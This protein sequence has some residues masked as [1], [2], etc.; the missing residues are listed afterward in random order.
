MAKGR[1]EKKGAAFVPRSFL[2]SILMVWRTDATAAVPEVLARQLIDSIAFSTVLHTDAEQAARL[3]EQFPDDMPGVTRAD[4][5]RALDKYLD[6][7]HLDRQLIHEVAAHLDSSAVDRSLRW[8]SSDSGRT[9]SKAESGAYA[10]M[11][12][13]SDF[14]LYHY[15]QRPSAIPAEDETSKA[16]DASGF[17]RFMTDMFLATGEQRA[18]VVTTVQS[19]GLCARWESSTEELKSDLRRF[20][21]AKLRGYYARAE[22]ADLG[23]Y[24]TYL[25]LHSSDSPEA[26]LRA[27][28][29]PIV[30]QAWKGALLSVQRARGR[31]P[32]PETQAAAQGYRLRPVVDYVDTQ[33]GAG[34]TGSPS[35][36]ILTHRARDI[37]DE[38]P[39]LNVMVGDPTVPKID[40]SILK[41]ATQLIGRSLALD[42]DNPETLMEAGYI[43]YLNFDLGKSTQL[44]ERARTL[45][46]TDPWLGVRLADL[47]WAQ[48]NQTFEKALAQRAADEFEKALRLALPTPAEDRAVYQLGPIYAFLNDVPRADA[49]YRR[50]LDYRPEGLP[51]AYALHR[52]AIFLLYNAKDVDASLKIMRQSEATADFPIGRAF[53]ASVLAVKAGSLKET[54]QWSKGRPYIA[55]AR[56]YIPDLPALLPDLARLPAGL[57]AV[58]GIAAAE[59]SGRL[60]ASIA[61]RVLVHSML[62]ANASQ[63]P[64]LLAFG[65]DVNYFDAED[66]TALH[67]AILADNVEAT[68]TL[69]ALGADPSAPFLDGRTP[70]QLA[71]DSGDPKR[72]EI[73][74]LIK[75]ALGDRGVSVVGT[76]LKAGYE[77]EIVRAIDGDRWGNS[78]AVGDHVVFVNNQCGYTDTSLACLNVEKIQD[79]SRQLDIAI[80]KVELVN[81][82]DIF[83]ELGPYKN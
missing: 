11:F 2:V 12:S 81:W 28:E 60:P 4:I 53:L 47:Y 34:T 55:E 19:N 18:C 6:Y 43:A 9:I 25:R 13:D 30:V 68:R 58:F 46:L 44:L 38:A 27:A 62:Y 80:P 21:E 83:K 15:F 42:P 5:R 70:T 3:L 51:R 26:V 37:L 48:A 39:D 73:F 40:D 41:K 64:K 56:R 24:R 45:G 76:P 75:Q 31:L 52:Y 22:A 7:G 33:D 20:I 10:S 8:W 77:Y 14:L 71:S 59:R 32:G 1:T 17:A 23:A 72:A 69:L 35:P 49:Y 79:L 67:T 65:A 57:P 61:G 16:V 50:F 82:P 74:A 29:L 78:L 66:G 63:I 54:G 36:A